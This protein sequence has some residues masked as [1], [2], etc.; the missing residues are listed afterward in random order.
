ML[1]ANCGSIGGGRCQTIAPNV[2]IL[3]TPVIH[4]AS[5]KGTLYVVAEMQS[6]TGSSLTFYHFLHALDVTTLKEGVGQENF[7]APVQLCTT[8]PCDQSVTSS[9]FSNKHIQRPGLLYGGDGYL[10]VAFSMMDGNQ[11]PLPN[12]AIFAY[13]ATNLGATPLY[14]ATT[15]GIN[16]ADGAGIWQGGA[17]PAY[18]PD[19]TAT[20]YVYFNTANVFYSPTSNPPDLWRQLYQDDHGG[21]HFASGERV[22]YASRSPK[23][24]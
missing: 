10:Y 6:G 16:F 1:P 20:E 23:P 4:I 21:Q 17:G 12:G 24:F 3:G 13:N 9:T 11:P 19:S 8:L 2:G 22:V 18:G 5:G 15:Q 7:G 14:L